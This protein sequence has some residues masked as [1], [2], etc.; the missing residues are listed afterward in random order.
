MYKVLVGTHEVGVVSAS[1]A[2]RLSEPT[3][4]IEDVELAPKSK[5]QITTCIIKH[6]YHLQLISTCLVL[7]SDTHI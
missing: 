5:L 2:P 1:S 7:G 3:C 4:N 6:S